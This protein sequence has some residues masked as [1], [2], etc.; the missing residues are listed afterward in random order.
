MSHNPAEKVAAQISD[1]PSA[2]AGKAL[3]VEDRYLPDIIRM[4]VEGIHWISTKEL[5]MYLGGRTGRPCP[6]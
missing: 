4:E 5:G 2:I 3:S 6:N 1:A